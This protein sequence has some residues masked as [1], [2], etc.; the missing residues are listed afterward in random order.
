MTTADHFDCPKCKRRKFD[1]DCAE[2]NCPMA[3]DN[4]TIRPAVFWLILREPGKVPE[5]KGSFRQEYLA[6]TLREFMVARPTAFITV[7]R[8]SEA[9]PDVQD[10]PEC[11]E[12]LDGRTTSTAAKHR[13]STRAAFGGCS[14]DSADEL[15][16][17]HALE[18]MRLREALGNLLGSIEN[19][20]TLDAIPCEAENHWAIAEARAALSSG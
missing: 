19:W 3:I 15:V 17:R 12:M 4:D 9:G 13:A 7:L 8:L 16:V 2:D 14:P 10:G 6:T 1:G 5:R 20:Q 18:I 11:L